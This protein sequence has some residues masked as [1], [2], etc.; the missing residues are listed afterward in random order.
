MLLPLVGVGQPLPPPPYLRI[1]E[2][3]YD[4]PG[5]SDSL[6]FIELR[7]ETYG[8]G[9]WNMD[10]FSFIEGIDFDFYPSVTATDGDLIII[11]QDSVA[12]ENTFGIEAY[13]WSG[14]ELDDIADS[15]VVRHTGNVVY[16]YL[17]YDA[18]TSLPQ[19]TAGNGAS[20]VWC[21]SDGWQA[22]Q[23]NTGIVVDGI[24]IYADPGEESICLTVQVKEV[25]TEDLTLYPN[26]TTSHINIQLENSLKAT[27]TQVYDMTGRLVHQQPFNPNMDVSHLD[28]GTYIVVVETEEGN[29]RGTVQKQ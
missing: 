16:S 29:F 10:V 7:A 22:S 26:P 12:F 5:T 9:T 15:I 3:M 8:N 17:S 1:I 13:Q 4:S 21:D 14:G 6:D 27:R 20:L 19:E 24:T 18:N 11:A 28:R 25:L 23:N 2:V